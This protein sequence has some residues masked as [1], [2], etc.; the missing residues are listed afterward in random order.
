[1]RKAEDWWFAGGEMEKMRSRIWR[2]TKVASFGVSEHITCRHHFEL[3]RN[4]S[5]RASSKFRS[6]QQFQKQAQKGEPTQ[7]TL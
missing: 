2:R 7:G 4:D 3:Q 1:M 6:L 5:L